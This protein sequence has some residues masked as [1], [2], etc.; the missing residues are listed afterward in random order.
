L[1]GSERASKTG[2]QGSTL[3]EGANINL[4]LMALGNVINALSEGTKKGVKKVRECDV[5]V[6][7]CMEGCC[8]KFVLL[9][10]CG[11]GFNVVWCCCVAVYR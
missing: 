9:L 5:L 11:M 2:A 3:K 1:A 4:S 7:R 6:C 10:C 8:M